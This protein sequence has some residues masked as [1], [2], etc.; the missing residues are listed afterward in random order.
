MRE[1]RE[2]DPGKRRVV[3]HIVAHCWLKWRG[4]V[5]HLINCLAHICNEAFEVVL[6]IEVGVGKAIVRQQNCRPTI[7]DVVNKHSS[8]FKS[9]AKWF[10]LV[11]DAK[12]EVM[13]R[14]GNFQAGFTSRQCHQLSDVNTSTNVEVRVCVP[15][16]ELE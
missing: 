13:D 10:S 12:R 9:I 2:G 5:S 14:S 11:G 16:E 1:A 6:V 4:A 3:N 7:D 8:I 15:D